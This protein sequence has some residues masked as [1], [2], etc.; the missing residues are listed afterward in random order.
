MSYRDPAAIQRALSSPTWAVVGLT[1][2]EYRA[3]HAVAA[4]L[5]AKG[6]GSCR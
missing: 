2:H 1:R 6:C 4:F 5:Q 3:A